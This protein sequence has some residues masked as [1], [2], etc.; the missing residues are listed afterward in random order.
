MVSFK[1]A[2]GMGFQI[3]IFDFVNL[4]NR[5]NFFKQELY[6]SI[7]DVKINL[8]E[9]IIEEHHQTGHRKAH[10]LSIYF[11]YKESIYPYDSLC[12]N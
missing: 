4:I 7:I 6:R 9:A 11:P 3:D 10:G 1:A 12:S 2:E 5:C 8:K